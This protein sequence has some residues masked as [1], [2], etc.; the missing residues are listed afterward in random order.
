MHE[1]AGSA[2]G[3]GRPTGLCKPALACAHPGKAKGASTLPLGWW[4]G[5]LRLSPLHPGRATGERRLP[6]PPRARL[7]P[8]TQR[9]PP[10]AQRRAGSPFLGSHAGGRRGRG[11]S[12]HAQPW[13]HDDLADE[14]T[15]SYDLSCG[16]E[17][18]EANTQ[19]ASELGQI[20]WEPLARFTL[21]PVS[22]VKSPVK[23]TSH[24]RSLSS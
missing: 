12:G 16:G 1:K 7:P 6:H 9:H 21:S 8:D 14:L 18:A 4:A 11:S 19:R 23:G 20:F 3:P 5:A 15:I 22:Q 13:G 24:R 10:A 17:Q 2:G